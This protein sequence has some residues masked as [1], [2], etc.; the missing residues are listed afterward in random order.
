MLGPIAATSFLG[1]LL[2]RCVIF[3]ITLTA[4]PA[5]V[6]RQ[7]AWTDATPPVSGS[8]INNGTQSATWTVKRSPGSRVIAA[9]ASREGSSGAVA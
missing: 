2:N 3:A 7:P 1:S 8:P 5:A 9:S 4:I 6:P